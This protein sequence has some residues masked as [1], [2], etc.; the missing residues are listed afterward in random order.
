MKTNQGWKELLAVY[1]PLV[2]LVLIGF[3]LAYQYIKPAPPDHILMASGEPG[4]AYD[5]FAR[6]YQKLLARQGIT[7]EIVDTHGSV[8][9]LRLLSEGRVDMAFVQ[10]GVAKP[11]QVGTRLESLGSLYYEPLWVF[12]RSDLDIDRL[13]DLKGLRLAIGPEGSGTRALVELLL[14]ENQ[15]PLDGAQRLSLDSGEAARRLHE[16]SIDVAFFVASPKS[17]RVAS[18]LHDPQVKLVNIQRATAY[19]RRHPFLVELTLPEGAEDLAVNI[20][21][22]DIH[23]LAA[24]SE[25]VIQEDLHP[26][27]VALMMQVLD[28][29]H[30]DAGWFSG[31]G[32]FPSPRHI[33]FPLSAEAERFYRDGPPFLQ[34]FLPF[35]AASL[36]D[37]TK[38]MILPLLGLLLP[39]F[40]V[41][42]PLYRWR[43]RARIYRWYEELQEVDR[44]ILKA[45]T[46]EKQVYLDK[47]D[48][49]EREVRDVVV[50]LSFAYQLYH[51][52]LHIDFVRQ[53]LQES[54]QS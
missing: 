2:L 43:M 33:S 51:L 38:I 14:Q 20:P 19:A 24:T 12:Q 54:H 10:G 48:E 1:G 5:A 53:K 18:L 45:S 6:R 44:N 42:P 32:E 22:K 47:L 30:R 25:L 28:K 8:D 23:L 13:T 37:R 3:M 9:N 11:G 15:I 49:L 46:Q 50:P 29:V 52:R 26:A 27:I 7:L 40:R 41:V 4:G 36:L 21:S 31:E 39:L 35:W 34:R 16:G 17:E